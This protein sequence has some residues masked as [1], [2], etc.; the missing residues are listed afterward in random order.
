MV[1]SDLPPSLRLPMTTSVDVAL[2]AQLGHAPRAGSARPFIVTSAD[3]VVMR[4]PGDALHAGD[5]PEQV[6]VDADGH[7]VHAV[8]G[9][10]RGRGGCRS[11]QFSDTVTTRVDAL[12]HPGL[13]L[14]ERVPAAA[15]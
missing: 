2:G 1:S 10:R 15:G 14:G 12:G 7:D 9:R 13:H 4:R 11:K 6:G 3:A 8:A 5:R